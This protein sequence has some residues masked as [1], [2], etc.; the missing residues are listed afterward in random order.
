MRRARRGSA[1]AVVGLV[2]ALAA[3]AGHADEEP[4]PFER[5]RSALQL[6]ATT[7]V[8]NQQIESLIAARE[9][10]LDSLREQLEG[11]EDLERAITPM[12]LRM[13][14]ALHR[15]VELDV[16]FR[17]DERMDRI[18]KLRQVMV[19][20]G[21]SK[22]DKFRRVM[23][24]I[25]IENEFGRTIEAY[26]AK[27]KGADGERDVDFLRFGRIALVY[28]TLDESEAG[29]WDQ[30]TRSWRPLDASYRSA[31]RQGLRIARKQAAP[32]LVRLPLPAPVDADSARTAKG[33]AG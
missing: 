8:Y 10:E 30:Q 3:P 4:T 21:K 9:A 6:T 5:Y 23:E 12:M 33:G 32:D 14:D 11:V 27:L 19:T 22:G 13:I 29:V 24:A 28:Q 1:L 7:R 31:I 20:P 26:R 15:F 25:Q 18:A 17:L 16:P 2:L